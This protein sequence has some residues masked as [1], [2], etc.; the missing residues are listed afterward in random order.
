MF[1]DDAE[2]TVSYP[3]TSNSVPFGPHPSNGV[4]SF[5]SGIMPTD[6][7]SVILLLGSLDLSALQSLGGGTVGELRTTTY[8]SLSS[9]SIMDHNSNAVV[10]IASNAALQVTVSDCSACSTSFY[11]SSSCT[12]VA[13]RVCTACSVC[14]QDEYSITECTSERD[15]TCHRTFIFIFIYFFS[16]FLVA[17]TTCKWPEYASQ[18]CSATMNR[19]CTVC[20]E[21]T[22]D[23]FEES[24]CTTRANRVCLTCDSCFLT[25]PQKHLCSYSALWQRRESKAPF[26]CP[27]VD[28]VYQTLEERLQAAKG[29]ACGSGRCSCTG[30]STG[31]HNPDGD[32]FPLDPRCTGPELYNIDL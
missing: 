12:D 23:E 21:C 13:D 2:G 31:N 11:T 7:T 18:D 3:L 17:C 9:L 28:D 8:L 26:G 22:H 27:S 14:G 24:R 30:S 4:Y 25:E 6:G 15:T 32:S 29:H 19:V 16:H 1:H 10:A 20:T 5:D